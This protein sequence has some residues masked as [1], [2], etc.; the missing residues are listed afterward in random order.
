MHEEEAGTARQTIVLPTFPA[1][2][3]GKYGLL[4]YG[5]N[6]L[7]VMAAIKNPTK[8]AKRAANMVYR[9]FLIPAAPKYTLMV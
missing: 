8:S 2:L 6:I 7:A 3:M 4:F 5:K 1:S 9:V